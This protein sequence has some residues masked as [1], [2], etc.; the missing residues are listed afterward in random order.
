MICRL[1]QYLDSGQ[2]LKDYEMDEKGM[3][4]AGL[5]RVVL[6]EEGLYNLLTELWKKEDEEIASPSKPLS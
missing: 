1:E 3:L 5:K 2:W 4:L 6:A